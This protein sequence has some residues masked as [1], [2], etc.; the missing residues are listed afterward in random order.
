MFAT[1][2]AT[3]VQ[4]AISSQAYA[5]LVTSDAYGIGAL[6]LGYSLRQH[7]TKRD[8][9]LLHTANV[10]AHL[11]TRLKKIW[12]KLI[13]VDPIR[14]GLAA[15][16][17]LLGRPELDITYTKLHLWRLTDYK[18]ITYLDADAYALR[19]V[20]ELF[21]FPKNGQQIAAAPDMG[22]PD[23]FNSGMFV[24]YPKQQTYDAL[25]AFSQSHES[26]DGGDQGLLNDYFPDWDRISFSFNMTPGAAYSYRPAYKRFGS[27]VSIVHFAGGE[28]PWSYDRF[29]DGGICGRGSDTPEFLKHIEGW[30]AIHDKYI[31][32][33]NPSKGA[34]S[35]ADVAWTTLSLSG[36]ATVA[37][38]IDPSDARP[39]WEQG[40]SPVVVTDGMPEAKVQPFGSYKIE[41]NADELREFKP[42]I[43]SE[44]NSDD[45]QLHVDDDA[46]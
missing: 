30:W 19:N 17:I 39:P 25:L 13:Q 8:L 35:K 36:H 27:A 6:V 15:N 33:W 32:G 29:Y 43:S 1:K 45:E 44:N 20:D 2:A 3:M 22:W 12:N 26:F 28:K 11:L 23:C 46:E 5:T 24:F 42:T 10:S 21:D 9:V 41:W 37:M 31:S 40:A 7:G 16:L 14:S 18:K 38:S 34:F 4:D